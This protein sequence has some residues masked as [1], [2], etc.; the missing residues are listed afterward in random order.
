M[1]CRWDL[2]SL[3]MA[4]VVVVNRYRRHGGATLR[5]NPTSLSIERTFVAVVAIC[6]DEG[7]CSPASWRCFVT[8][9]LWRVGGRV[10]VPCLEPP[11]RRGSVSRNESGCGAGAD[12]PTI[13]AMHCVAA[14]TA[15]VGNGDDGEEM[16]F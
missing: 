9:S 13:A 6:T 15:G 14:G 7:A 4:V 3:P 12:G 5:L 8:C 10:E 11:L 1:G 2:V 16:P